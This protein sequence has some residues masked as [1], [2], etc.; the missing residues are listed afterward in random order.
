[1]WKKKSFTLIELLVV[2]AIIAVL[3]ALLLPAVAS[4]RAHARKIACLSNQRQVGLGYM[5]YAADFTGHYPAAFVDHWNR[6]YHYLIP[7]IGYGKYNPSDA[8]DRSKWD[9]NQGA[10]KLL[11]CPGRDGY[12][13]NCN[14]MLYGP[15]ASAPYGLMLYGF[16][17][18]GYGGSWN[19]Q[20]Y[21]ASENDFSTASA[22]GGFST[23][24]WVMVFESRSPGNCGSFHNWF[25]CHPQGSNV[26]TADGSSHFWPIDISDQLAVEFSSLLG[27]W[28]WY[29]R[30]NWPGYQG[31]FAAPGYYLSPK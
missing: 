28:W 5:T 24:H 31:R 4:A 1:M 18:V 29:W 7:Y 20:G 22:M 3:V 9:F 30:V 6:W 2:V 16:G 19:Y 21:F 27:G 15:D 26:L 14:S 10:P 25:T 13:M 11:H 23:D 12:G 8:N 17:R